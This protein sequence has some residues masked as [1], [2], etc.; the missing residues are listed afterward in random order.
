MNLLHELVPLPV[1][2]LGWIALLPSLFLAWRQVRPASPGAELAQHVWLGGAVCVAL[3][4]LLTIKVG[5][6]PAFGMLGVGLYALL[7]GRAR[8][9]LG[10]TFAV[11]LHTACTHGAWVN[12]GLNGV[13]FALV[14]SIVASF[15]QRWI[16]SR[17]PHH[18]FVFIFGNGMFSSFICTAVTAMLLFLVSSAVESSWTRMDLAQYLGPILLLAWSEAIVSGML[19]SALVIFAPQVVLT[20]TQDRYLPRTRISPR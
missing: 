19:F 12:I 20:Y 1:A 16:E 8:A 13:L 17:L 11:I 7:F 10:L 5:N 15:C 9:L 2:L 18:L 6:G 3:L 4:W 14:P